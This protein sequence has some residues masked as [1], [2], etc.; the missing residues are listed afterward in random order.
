MFADQIGSAALTKWVTMRI[1]MLLDNEFSEDPRVKNEVETLQAEGHQVHVLCL[2]HGT[3]EAEESFHGAKI[4]RLPI[5]S[6]VKN[7]M[8]GLTQ[9]PFDAWLWFWFYQAQKRIKSLSIEAI[10]CHDLY[11]VPPT[12]KLKKK[13]P[14]IL[15]VADLHENYPEALKQYQYTQ[16]FPGN[17]LI[18]IPKWERMEPV[19]LKQCDRVITVIEEAVDRY[20]SLGLEATKLHV[21]ANYVN[22]SQYQLD[23]SIDIGSK[24]DEGF[25]LVYTGGFDVHRG[26]ETAVEAV[27]IVSQKIP[28][29]RLVLVGGGRTS[30]DLKSLVRQLGLTD[31]VFFEG[32]Q[33]PESLPSY[34]NMADVCLIPHLK[35]VHTDNTIPHK[36]F[37]YL[38]MEKAVVAS[39]CNPMAR[40]IE[41]SDCGLIHKA[42]DAEDL[43]RC[44][45]QLYDDPKLRSRLATNGKKEVMKNYTWKNAADELLRIYSQNPSK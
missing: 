18:S 27:R 41:A 39:N 23:P 22:L 1:L 37:H 38:L 32:W 2:N 42:A 21:V 44:I 16:T 17:L 24:F 35:T 11:M 8:K 3:R 31:K 10:H 6:F 40:I 12:L 30:D 28:D 25:N 45:I 36:L 13:Y 14:E 26:L 34:V 4:E 19:W 9:T 20:M 5:S 7:K 29:C 43:A 15:V 33:K